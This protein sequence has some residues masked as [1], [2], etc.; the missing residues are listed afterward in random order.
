MCDNVDG[1]ADTKASSMED[2]AKEDQ[3]SGE[4]GMYGDVWVLV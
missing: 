1:A 4:E 3:E 2:A